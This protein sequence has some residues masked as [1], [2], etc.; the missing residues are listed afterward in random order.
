MRRYVLA[1]D[2]FARSRIEAMPQLEI[3]TLGGSR[4]VL[5][6]GAFQGF[7]TRKVEALAIYLAS[8]G[9]PQPREFLADLLWD[10][11]SQSRALSNLR[12]ALTNLRKHLDAYFIITRDSAAVNPEADVWLDAAE[13]ESKVSEGKTS[14]S[15]DD[16]N[17][18]IASA[19]ALYRGELETT[20]LVSNRRRAG[21]D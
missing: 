20:R 17:S 11:R 18:D 15:R 10:D 14:Q 2:A 1:D 3:F 13:L 12:V 8:T 6:G 19:V 21:W 9:R 5:E 7:S 4:F 16:F